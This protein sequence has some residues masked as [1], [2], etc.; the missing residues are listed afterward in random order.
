MT[1]HLTPEDLERLEAIVPGVESAYLKAIQ[2]AEHG[3]T[4]P[5]PESCI[6]W[7]CEQLGPALLEALKREREQ[8]LKELIT[9]ALE[10]A[11]W[12]STDGGHHK[13]WVIDQMVRALTGDGY[14]AWVTD[15]KDGEEGPETYGWDEGVSP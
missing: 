8:E 2:H 15:H 7:L 13:M 10:F 1:N 14:E 9:Q 6:E 3:E 11:H 4:F 5:M 12:G